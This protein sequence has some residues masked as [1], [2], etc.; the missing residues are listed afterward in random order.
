M[1][2]RLGSNAPNV[3]TIRAILLPLQHTRTFRRNS[4]TIKKG[5]YRSAAFGNPVDANPL[6]QRASR[7]SYSLRLP[8]TRQELSM[9]SV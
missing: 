8:Q 7:P 9:L 1:G 5:G 2:W 4:S 3:L 6:I